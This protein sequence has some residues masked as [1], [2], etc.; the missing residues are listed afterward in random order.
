[1]KNRIT[2]TDEDFNPNFYVCLGVEPTASRDIIMKAFKQQALKEHPDKGGDAEKFKK[3]VK[4]HE[5]LTDENKRLIYDNLL[6]SKQE[7]KL[8]APAAVA[9]TAAHFQPVGLLQLLQRAKP[10]QY[11]TAPG[12]QYLTFTDPASFE[13]VVNKLR[14]HGYHEGRK[15]D[16]QVAN[17]G[18]LLIIGGLITVNA[19]NQVQIAPS[20][21]ELLQRG[22]LQQHPE[23]PE[24]QLLVFPDQLSFDVAVTRLRQQKYLEGE[25]KDF[26]VIS[27]A[28][29]IEIGGPITTNASNQVQ[30]APST[31][32]LLQEGQ[33]KRFDSKPNK[34]YLLFSD[35]PSFDAAVARL[36]QQKYEEG[37]GKDFRI[38]G[39]ALA[40]EIGGHITV[41]ASNQVQIAPPPTCGVQH[42]S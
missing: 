41:D 22:Q 23:R 14:E 11:L 6:I 19:N 36:R 26:Q 28:R 16:F 3:L 32:M 7:I 18:S 39:I 30:V 29:T 17:L 34:Q 27:Q 12:I 25:E 40:L 24:K 42:R 10:I 2:F 31:M 33:P 1:M 9:P 15:G 4:A 35:R 8:S 37:E 21:A 20:N 13:A 5:I 38:A